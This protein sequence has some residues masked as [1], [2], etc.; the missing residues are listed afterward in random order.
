M[1]VCI[2]IDAEQAMRVVVGELTQDLNYN[3]DDKKLTKAIKRVL[4]Y[5]TTP[6]QFE[7]IISDL[8]D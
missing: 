6:E 2:E 7:Q 8:E 5:Y 1:R 4:K 3:Q